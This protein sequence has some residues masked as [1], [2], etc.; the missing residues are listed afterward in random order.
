MPVERQCRPESEWTFGTLGELI[1]PL[2]YCITW[3]DDEPEPF[4]VHAKDPPQ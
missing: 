4:I 1:K 3:E 2:T